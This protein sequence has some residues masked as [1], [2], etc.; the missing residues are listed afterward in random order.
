MRWLIY[1]LAAVGAMYIGIAIWV[2]LWIAW[3]EAKWWWHGKPPE[4]RKGPF[5]D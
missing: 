3:G 5:D 1:A 4:R 2:L